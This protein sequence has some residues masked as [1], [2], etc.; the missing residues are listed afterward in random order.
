MNK[1]MREEVEQIRN[2]GVELKVESVGQGCYTQHRID[3]PNGECLMGFTHTSGAVQWLRG[4]HTC[5]M[6][7]VN[8]AVE[9]VE[10]AT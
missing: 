2:L 5:L 8:E 1:K 7:K 3:G 9:A 4:F 6:L 10:A